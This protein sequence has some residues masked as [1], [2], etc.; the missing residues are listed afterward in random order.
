MA[1]TKKT[2]LIEDT[3]TKGM[4]V[5]IKRSQGIDGGLD[6]MFGYSANDVENKSKIE[7]VGSGNLLLAIKEYC[8]YL[9]VD[10]GLISRANQ[11]SYTN[12]ILTPPEISQFI[13]ATKIYGGHENYGART[14]EFSSKLIQTS[15]GAGNNDFLI[16]LNSIN[17]SRFC[18]RI[19]GKRDDRIKIDIKGNSGNDFCN[20]SKYFDINIDGNVSGFSLKKTEKSVITVAGNCGEKFAFGSIDITSFVNGNVGPNSGQESNRLNLIVGG[21]VDY[22][23]A[24][25]ANRLSAVIGGNLEIF[26]LGYYA[27]NMDLFVGGSMDY[28]NKKPPKNIRVGQ[29]AKNHSLYKLMMTELHKRMEEL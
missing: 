8:S 17:L 29:N 15:Y 5:G 26:G 19:K 13:L 10:F 28:G 22:N 18:K 9:D 20:G 24:S 3:K 27:R 12:V 2:T 25:F 23:F 16:N 6:N 1:N 11:C 7:V 14:G 4:S 21:N